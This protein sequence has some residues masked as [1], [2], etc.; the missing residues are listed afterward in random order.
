VP[1][2][3]LLLLLL[4]LLSPLRN[5][6]PAARSTGGALR[7]FGSSTAMAS[8]E[9]A[10]SGASASMIAMTLPEGEVVPVSS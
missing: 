7:A 5:G 9:E 8:V 4:L 6:E 3:L 1:A 10:L 2:C